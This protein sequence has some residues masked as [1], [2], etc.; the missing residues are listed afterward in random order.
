MH[1]PN[2]VIIHNASNH[3]KGYVL[4]QAIAA[5]TES[6]VIY[7]DIDLPFSINSMMQI[8]ENLPMYDVVFGIKK[9][10]YYE[11]LPLQRKLVSKIL[12]KLIKILFPSLPVS[13]TQCGL[14]GMNEKGKAIFLQ[15][16]IDRYLFDLEFILYASKAKLNL[17]PIP[18][19]LRE[20]IVFGAMN[21]KILLQESKNLWKILRR[22]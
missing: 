19:S 17:K 21:Y 7:T 3:G 22:K 10:E 12:Q 20:G 14:K 18:V 16:K 1:C 15:T 8:V 6:H 5:T 11:Q 13:D 2:A 4:R 9:N